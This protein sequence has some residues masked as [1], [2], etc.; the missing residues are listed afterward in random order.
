MKIIIDTREQK[1]YEFD[2]SIRKT[3]KAGDY[4]I[5]GLEQLITVERKSKEDIYQSFGNGRKRFEREFQKLATYD[6]AAIVVEAS[7]DNLL[8]QPCYT[9]L[10]PKTVINSIISWSI[11]YKTHFYFGC[12]RLLSQ[13][14]VYRILEKYYK[15]YHIVNKVQ[16]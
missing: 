14:L 8:K 10:N 9:K 3:L 16:T 12:N 4:S 2:D 7:L 6:Y 1:P 11:K 5:E 13:T 15:L